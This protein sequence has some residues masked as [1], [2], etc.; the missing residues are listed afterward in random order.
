[1]SEQFVFDFI[2]E[3]ELNINNIFLRSFREVRK[4]YKRVEGESID[5][6]ISFLKDETYLEVAHKLTEIA[7]Y[8]QKINIDL[9][10][11]GKND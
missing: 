7:T 9:I 6:Y 2:K 1:M 3:E 10:Y 5:E 4:K 11:G 8:R